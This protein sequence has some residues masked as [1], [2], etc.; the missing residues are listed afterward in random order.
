MRWID[1]AVVLSDWLRA[2]RAPVDVQREAQEAIQ[3]FALA[4]DCRR[5]I[6]YGGAKWRNKANK[7]HYHGKKR[8]A[9]ALKWQTDYRN[10]HAPPIKCK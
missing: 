8:Y 5:Q 1:K 10:L 2:H 6:D 7:A 9:V 3:Y 4:T